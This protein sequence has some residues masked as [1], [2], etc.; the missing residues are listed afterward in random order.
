VR[1]FVNDILIIILQL[2]R[3]TV[4][5]KKKRI[6]RFENLKANDEFAGK[7]QNSTFLDYV[8]QNRL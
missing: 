1:F 5:Q 3:S 2:S 6:I 7:L 4:K 8:I